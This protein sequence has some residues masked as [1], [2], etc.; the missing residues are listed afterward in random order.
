MSDKFYGGKGGRE[1]DTFPQKNCGTGKIVSWALKSLVARG[2]GTD[3]G[4]SLYD[5]HVYTRA[6]ESCVHAPVHQQRGGSK[7]GGGSRDA[8][9][10]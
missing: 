3:L 5:P 10:S 4:R 2:H 6:R 8:Y 1:K 7:T 9:F